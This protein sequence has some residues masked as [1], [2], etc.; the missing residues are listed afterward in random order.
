MLRLR[1]KRKG[2]T[3]FEYVTLIIIILGVFITIGNYFKRGIQGRWKS[4]V[5]EMGEQYDPR[6]AVSQVFHTIDSKTNTQ[7][8]TLDA[9]GGFYSSRT[10]VTN[11]LERTQGSI[12]V[13]AY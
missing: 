7:I 6:A 4:A 1:K 12:A 2:Q 5:D 8:I 9:P 13:G 10:D 3:T 11:S